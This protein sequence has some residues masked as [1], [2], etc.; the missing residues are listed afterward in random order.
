MRAKRHKGYTPAV[1]CQLNITNA[2]FNQSIRSEHETDGE[3]YRL[4]VSPAPSKR[5]CSRHF[6]VPSYRAATMMAT[7][8]APTGETLQ[9]RSKGKDVRISNIIAAKASLILYVFRVKIAS[10][11]WRAAAMIFFHCLLL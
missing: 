9:E 2:V 8:T 5:C 3:F 10:I 6:S 1:F 11:A 7:G 4:P